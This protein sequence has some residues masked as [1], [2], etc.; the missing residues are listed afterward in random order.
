MQP[1]TRAADQHHH[2]FE[3]FDEAREHR[4]VVLVRNLAGGRREQ[5]ERQNEDRGDQE[6]CRFRVD[7]GKARRLI[8]H[9]RRKADL[10]DVV[11][12]RA[13]ELGPEK[14]RETALPEQTELGVERLV[15]AGGA[16][17]GR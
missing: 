1:E 11:V 3:S 10:E 16:T 6:R 13:E 17:G 15:R 8:R 7:A 9:Q 2:D 4:L 5:H 14:R 12:H